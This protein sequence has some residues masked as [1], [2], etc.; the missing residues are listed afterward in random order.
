MKRRIVNETFRKEFK[1]K[2]LKAALAMQFE[3]GLSYGTCFKII[4]KGEAP[5][6]ELT[7]RLASMPFGMEED[8]MFPIVQED[9]AA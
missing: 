9:T 7:R 2:H 1:K 3:T 5:A 4:E 8:E 6:K